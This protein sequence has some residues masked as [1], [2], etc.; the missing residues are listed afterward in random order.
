MNQGKLITFEGIEC[1]GKGTQIKLVLEWLKQLNINC[2]AEHEPGGTLYGE[3]LR[4]IL[5]NPELSLPAIFNAVK[6]HSDYQALSNF[7][8]NESTDYSRNGT[9]E[10]FMFL[11]SRAL[12]AE[13]IK[14]VI[15][16]GTTVIS[17]RLMD[18]TTAYQGGGKAN[19]D[20]QMIEQ[21][22]FGNHLAMGE[23]WPNLTLFLDISVDEMYRRMAGETDEKNS[24]FEKKY[25]RNFYEKV[26]Q[27]YLNIAEREPQRFV[28]IDGAKSPTE[29]FEIIKTKLSK[30]LNI[31]PNQ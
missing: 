11:A 7:N 5:K 10:M 26:R 15:E 28:V 30:L 20:P 1:S 16:Q 19:S 14:E 21:I 6:G 12:Y 31:N 22:N 13:K 9:F 27:E 17:D 29:V 25:D 4:A 23:L 8:F 24:F 18:S 3:A 2:T